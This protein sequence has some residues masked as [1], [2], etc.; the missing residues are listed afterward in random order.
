M[1]RIRARVAII[2]II[3]VL[4]AALAA[5]GGGGGG[6]GSEDPNQVLDQTFNNPTKVTSGNLDI[7]LN[8][9]AEGTQSGSLTA[10]IDRAV[11]GRRQQPDH[12]PPAR[13]DRQGQRLR[14]RVRAST[15]TAG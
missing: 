3:A 11:P 12:V 2:A 14:A 7:S 10:T 15:S 8:G 4:P 9:T 6:G 13:P 5:C 1:T